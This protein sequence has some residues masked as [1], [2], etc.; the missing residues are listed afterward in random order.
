MADTPDIGK[1][2]G[3]IMENPDLISRISS[4]AKGAEAEAEKESVAVESNEPTP[5][6]E[7]AAAPVAREGSSKINRH[8]LLSAMKPYLSEER[9]RAI[10]SM[11]AIGEIFDAMKRR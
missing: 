9:C 10:D 8:R 3:L 1:I 5:A 2:I 11:S 7:A 4:L 6:A